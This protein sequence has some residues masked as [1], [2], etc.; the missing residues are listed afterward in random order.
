MPPKHW[1]GVKLAPYFSCGRLRNGCMQL[2]WGATNTFA[3]IK[4][5]LQGGR[6]ATPPDPGALPGGSFPGLE[7]YAALYQRCW[8]QSPGERPRLAEVI[9]T[10]RCVFSGRERGALLEL[11]GAGCP[12]VGKGRLPRV[13]WGPCFVAAAHSGGCNT[14]WC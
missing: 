12:L 8:G 6:P 14:G 3:I 2:P 11:R 4:S 9:A 10:L 1:Q 7:E 5:V 13:R